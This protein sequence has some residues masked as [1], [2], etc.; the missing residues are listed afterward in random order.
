MKYAPGLVFR[1]GKKKAAPGQPVIRSFFPLHMYQL[2]HILVR[3]GKFQYHFFDE[4][5]PKKFVEEFSSPQEAD[6]LIDRLQT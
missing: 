3:E 1:V 4:T 6:N 2:S 5:N